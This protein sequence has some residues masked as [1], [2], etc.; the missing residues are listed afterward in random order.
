VALR[1]RSGFRSHR[2][3]CASSCDG[4]QVWFTHRLFV[5]PEASRPPT[6]MILSRRSQLVSPI[7][8]MRSSRP[9][10]AG[11][12]GTTINVGIEFF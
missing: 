12:F 7:A 2:S 3:S 5:A 10:E 9:L 1:V 8:G 4:A 11:L 6:G